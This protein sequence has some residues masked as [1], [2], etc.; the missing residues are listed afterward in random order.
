MSIVIDQGHKHLN[1]ERSRNRS[2]R[3][4]RTPRLRLPW[5]RPTPP[6]TIETRSRLHWHRPPPAS[7][8]QTNTAR[9]SRLSSSHSLDIQG[10]LR[11]SIHQAQLQYKCRR[12]TANSASLS[13]QRNC[14]SQ[15]LKGWQRY[16]PE[17]LRSRWFRPDIGL[18]R[19]RNPG[20]NHPQHWRWHRSCRQKRLCIQT[21]VGLTSRAPRLHPTTNRADK[22]PNRQSWAHHILGRRD[23]T[24][25]LPNSQKMTPQFCIRHE[26]SRSPRKWQFLPANSATLRFRRPKHFQS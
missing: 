23:R 5:P 9:Q 16:I 12:R 13:S 26:W 3:H 17:A 7:S 2:S 11:R 15:C 10:D 8:P 1:P 22:R 4:R 14:R 20:R 19:D 25:C 18:Q 24:N 6:Q 21:L